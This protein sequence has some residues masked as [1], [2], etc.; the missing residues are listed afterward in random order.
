[1]P[2]SWVQQIRDKH[3]GYQMDYLPDER[4]RVDGLPPKAATDFS[5]TVPAQSYPRP[6]SPPFEDDRNCTADV[7]DSSEPILRN[8]MSFENDDRSNEEGSNGQTIITRAIEGR[9]AITKSAITTG[10][11][12]RRI[13][14]VL[15]LN[16]EEMFTLNQSQDVDEICDRRAF[17]MFNP[18]EHVED[19][20]LIQR[21]LLI[22]SVEIFCIQFNG[23]WDG[24]KQ[25]ILDGGSGVI[26][27]HP[28]FESFSEVPEFGEVLR[29]DVRLWSVGIQEDAQFSI[30][31]PSSSQLQ[32]GRFEIFPHGGIIYITDS[33]FIEKPQLALKIVELF[34]CKIEASRKVE[35][36]VIPGMY[37]DDGLLVWRLGVRPE[38]MKWIGDKCIE[39]TAEIA[40]GDPDDVR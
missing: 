22:N 27:A 24:F 36:P 33:V 12:K 10:D 35:G 2:P 21:W 32:Y 26:I 9:H 5:G 4:I 8:H 14:T 30:W 28:E 3:T 19:Y 31:D 38:L 23:A 13:E 34:F 18:R 17:L 11:L 20:Q 6:D 1:M 7:A 40:A 25:C 15:K 29:R 16:F 37:I 39:R